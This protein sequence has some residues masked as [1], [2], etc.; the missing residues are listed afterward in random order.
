[1]TKEL[2]CFYFCSLKD[3]SGHR[4]C[5]TVAQP[6]DYKCYEE[7]QSQIDPIR[8]SNISLLKHLRFTV[9]AESG[10]ASLGTVQEIDVKDKEGKI[11]A[12]ISNGIINYQ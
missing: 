11:I 9:D 8:P 12:V 6:L 3:A 2:T 10:H 5:T 4:P 1:M 7:I